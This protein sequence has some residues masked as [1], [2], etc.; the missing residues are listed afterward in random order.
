M[1]N[2]SADTAFA[3]LKDFQV[4]TAEYVLRRLY[5]D[6]E[7]TDRF[8]VADEVGMGKTLVARHVIAGAIAR[9][10]HDD[11]VDRID[12]IYICSN[13]YIARQNIA[14]LDVRG[15]GAKPLSTRITMLAT[16][17]RDLNRTMPDGSKTVNLV[18][19][20]PGTSFDKGHRSGR[21]EE[22]A[23]LNWLLEPVMEGTRAQRNALQRILRMEVNERRW[24]A[25]CTGLDD[26]EALPDAMVTRKFRTAIRRSRVIADLRELIDELYGRSQLNAE[27]NRRRLAIVGALRRELAKVSVDC[28]EPDLVILDEFQRFKHLLERP[29][30]DAE[31][32]VSELAHDLFTA[33]Q[34]K[35][36][37]LSATP[38]KM[39]TLAEERELTG[40]DHYSDFIGTVDFLEQPRD[41]GTTR[42]LKAALADFRRLVVTGGD[43]QTAKNEVEKLLRKVMCRTERP[44]SGTA[45]MLIERTDQPAP[46]TADDLLGFVALKSIADEVGGA[47]SV[48]YWKS[49][50]YFL[51]FMDGYQLS[52][53][54]RQH[55]LD[56]WS[57][58]ALL[59]NAQVIRRSDLRGSG[60]I[61]PGN[62]RLR[63]LM[64]ET[65]DRGLWRLLWLPPSMPYHEPAGPYAEIDPATA[66]KRL[67][68]SSWAAAPTA[69]ASLLS[70]T[71]THRMQAAV[72]GDGPTRPRLAYRMEDGRPAGMTALALFLPTPGLAELTDPLEF[73]RE[74]PGEVLPAES[75][76]AYAEARV[77]SHVGVARRASS[78]L[79]RDTWFWAAPFAI[80]ANGQHSDLFDDI[81]E[82]ETSEDR[83]LATHL[84]AADQAAL[85]EVDLGAH[86]PDLDRWVAMVG[87]AGPANVAWRALRRVTAGIPA[88]TDDGIRRS[89]AVI[90]A[91]FRSL[92]NRPEVMALLDS[93]GSELAYWQVVLE[94]CH[95]GNLQA[96]L[97]EYLHHLVGNQNPLND[98]ALLALAADVRSAIALRG[99]VL[100]GF[101]PSRPETP[102]RFNARFALRYGSAKGTPKTDEKSVERMSVVQAAFNSPFW[103]LVLASTSIG[104]EGIDLHWWCHSLVHWNL[105]ANPADFEQREGRV[106][107]FKGHA[108]R[109]NVGAAHREEALRSPAADPWIAA[110]AAAELRRQPEMNDLWPWWTYPG[111]SKIERWIPSFPLSKDQQREFRL[112]V[113]RALYRLAFG[114]PRQEDL[115]S[116]L[117][118]QGYADDDERLAHLRIDLR[119]PKHH[120][121]RT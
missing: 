40:D 60:E 86:P 27:Q 30:A 37:L 99:A 8:L 74:T 26:P 2:H 119:P 7:A 67:I 20:T 28:L 113:Q 47:L 114:Q 103:P 110:F 96:V 107:R 55:D 16:Q 36:L 45:D 52:E 112:K 19:F 35:V 34:V 29:E 61:E 117:D 57:R 90:G 72:E 12:I 38:Y 53:K 39:F 31:R 46:P 70:W 24:E 14:K 10:Q 73:A 11:S 80:D 9:L 49:A 84:D 116:I 1:N 85:D 93:Q 17:L 98:D 82:S 101:D 94:Y 75:A 50:P 71:A 109:K 111:D 97:D 102:L 104:Q 56:P 13:A 51:N 21:V 4:D 15:D 76:L 83:G 33:E 58:R 22:R 25:I 18:A 66:T 105:P 3:T 92:F 108:V 88:L 63:Q 115:V 6:N 32:E 121:T 89:A 91:G 43:P 87:V 59:T 78:S 118:L 100:Q 48:E 62:A 106:H 5:D 23:L 41:E 54:F 81:R 77:A 44:V 42:R 65:V 68:F 69:I 95:G 120:A 79:S 64:T